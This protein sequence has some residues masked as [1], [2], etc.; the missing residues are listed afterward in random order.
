VISRDA[1]Y[2]STIYVM[3]HQAYVTFTFTSS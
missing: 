3:L 1:L 2:K